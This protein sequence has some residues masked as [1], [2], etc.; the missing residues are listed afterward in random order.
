MSIPYPMRD[1][2]MIFVDG[3]NLMIELGSEL[4]ISLRADQ[5]TDEALSMACQC[6]TQSLN[7]L[8]NANV[9]PFRVVRSYWFG[10]IQGS[11][12]LL[13]AKQTTLRGAGYEGILF[14]KVKGREEK[15]VD[16]AV[17]REMLMH[18][19]HKNY[20]T[21]VLVAGDEDYLGLVQDLKRLGLVVAGLFFQSAALSSRLRLAFDHFQTM[22]HPD[23]VNP[24]LAKILR[25]S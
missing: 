24:T 5:P 15:G 8:Q 21:A 4:G 2:A 22:R 9:G 1:P 19:F 18:G 14:S 11:P 25:G 23:A 6:V 12:D 10:S 17:A 20:K 16:L 7:D 13:Q 3:S